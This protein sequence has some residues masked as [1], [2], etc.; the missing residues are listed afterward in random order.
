MTESLLGD[1]ERKDDVV[2]L[3]L[4]R[5][6][7]EEDDSFRFRERSRVISLLVLR[8]LPLRA[9]WSRPRPSV[10]VLLGGERSPAL[11]V[12]VVVLMVAVFEINFVFDEL[13][14]PD[15]AAAEEDVVRGV[16]GRE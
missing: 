16:E 12:M 4:S 8:S 9:L 3:G 2:V 15:V 6:W 10:L 11:V 13:P 5:R 7:K 1:T 14:W